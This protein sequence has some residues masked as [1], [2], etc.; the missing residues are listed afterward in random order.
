MANSYYVGCVNRVG[1]DIGGSPT[2]VYYGSS[3]F[4]DFRGQILSQA[5]DKE[6]EVIY[7]DSIWRPWSE[8]ATN[9]PGTATDVLT[10][11]AT[12]SSRNPQRPSHTGRA[13]AQLQLTW[14]PPLLEMG[15]VS[16]HATTPRGPVGD[17]IREARTKAYGKRVRPAILM[18]LE[19]PVSTGQGLFSRGHQGVAAGEGGLPRRPTSHRPW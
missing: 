18:S 13:S 19:I 3:F 7:A 6:D 15:K 2:Q 9:V 17:T 4:A 10:C 11:T 5:N 14:G 1:L 12:W 16:E 8:I